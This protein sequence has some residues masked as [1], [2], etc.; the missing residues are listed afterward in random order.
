MDNKV[1][2]M[3]LKCFVLLFIISITNSAAF[4]LVWQNWRECVSSPGCSCTLTLQDTS[5]TTTTLKTYVVESAG[6]FLKSH[7]AFQQFLYCV[8]MSESSGADSADLKST[9][10]SAIEN[11]EKARA[12]YATLKTASEKLPYNHEMID[13]LLKFDYES[14]RLKNGLNEPIFEKL[15]AFLGKG[16]IAGFDTAVIANIDGI[17]NKLF[18]IKASVDKGSTPEISLPWRTSQ[19]YAEAQ[20][21]GQYM[22][23][24]FR[25]ILF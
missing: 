21:F 20:L 4:A 1:K 15:R 12:A 8:E 3:I 6:Y 9:L 25:D 16:D 17:L 24:V 7:A 13:Q 2:S 18:V 14:F 19:A 10:Y 22:S 5:E 23:E 11:M